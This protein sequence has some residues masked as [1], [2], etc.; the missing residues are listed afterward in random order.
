MVLLFGGSLQTMNT[1]VDLYPFA[2]S[3]TADAILSLQFPVS[4]ALLQIL[5]N[6]LIF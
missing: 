6:D 5:L 4:D 3:S 1:L 2:D